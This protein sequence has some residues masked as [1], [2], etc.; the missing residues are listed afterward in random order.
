[1][2]STTRSLFLIALML[3]QTLAW[4]TPFVVAAKGE[5]IA[6]MTVH[7]HER[8]HH[9]HDDESLHLSSDADSEPHFH[10]DDGFQP[11]GLSV[12]AVGAVFNAPSDTVPAAKLV[13]PRSVF[14]DGLL[15]PPRA[16]A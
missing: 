15:R 7:Q 13:Q 3:W 10:A 11:T 6:H 8:D 12:T 14:L 2:R 9:H 4:V 5:Q 1:V 16:H